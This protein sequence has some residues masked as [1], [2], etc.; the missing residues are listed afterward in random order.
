MSSSVPPSF[1][2]LRSTKTS[3][4][5]SMV[6]ALV[7][8]ASLLACSD[9]PP[10]N[11]SSLPRDAGGDAIAV[12][13]LD[14][15]DSNLPP[16]R[17]GDSCNPEG[18]RCGS[19]QL[20]LALKEGVGVCALPDCTME[21]P[22]TSTREDSCPEATACTEISIEGPGGY[23]YRTFCMRTCEPTPDGNPCAEHNKYLACSP[24]SILAT[25][26]TEVCGVLACSSDVECSPGTP[27]APKA[28][29]NTAVNLCFAD[30]DPNAK[31]GSP[32]RDSTEC[33]AGQICLPEIRDGGK[34]YLPG[35]Y[36]SKVGCRYGEPW[37]CPVDSGCYSLG[38]AQALSLCMQVGCNPEAPAES[39]GCRDQSVPADAYDCLA[40]D[41]DTVC[42]QPPE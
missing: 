29:C 40:V 21:V 4:S 23:E 12:P 24:A 35:G 14:E 19:G 28:T 6:A 17:I 27:T 11:D 38:A 31:I 33:G 34:I 9:T 7:A 37:A 25:G 10:T 8:T 13:D 20:C 39:D 42:W 22:D 2:T 18:H 32:C 15:N 16:L 5:L 3:L 41:D 30:G 36:C 1:C 26:Y